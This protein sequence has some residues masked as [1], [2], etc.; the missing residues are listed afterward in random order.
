M[1]EHVG[2]LHLLRILVHHDEEGREVEGHSSQVVGSGSSGDEFQVAIERGLPSWNRN[3]PV[4]V[5]ERRRQGVKVIR[6]CFQRR[7]RWTRMSD[8]SP[9]Y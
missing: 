2:R 7:V 6:A 3:S 1:V 4:G 5:E 8:G 9:L